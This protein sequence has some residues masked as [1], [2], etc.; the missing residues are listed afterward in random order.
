VSEAAAIERLESA[1]VG[2]DADRRRRALI[3]LKARATRTRQSGAP[4][5]ENAALLIVR[6][7]GVP[8]RKQGLRTPLCSLFEGPRYHE[9]GTLRAHEEGLWR[10][11]FDR[12]R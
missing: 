7:A 9:A 12:A 1:L 3:N 4:D 5:T 10:P 11:Q 2:G 8:P 6:A